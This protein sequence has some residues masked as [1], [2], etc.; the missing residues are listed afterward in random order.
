MLFVSVD[1]FF[2][3]AQR[4][5]RL[6]HDEEKQ[7]ALQMKGGDAEARQK[8]IHSYY[9]LLASY[10]KRMP[11]ELQ[12]LKAVYSFLQSLEAGIDNFHFQQDSEP[13]IHHLSWRM[14]QCITRCIADRP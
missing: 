3:Q 11:K 14:R 2:Q 10:V 4:A 12:T 9:P 1:D 6:T 5:T 13:F 7:L 8:L